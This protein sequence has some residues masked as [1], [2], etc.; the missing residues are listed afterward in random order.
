VNRRD[1]FKRLA[2]AGAA[3][4][5]LDGEAL[6]VALKPPI[7]QKAAQMGMTSHMIPELWARESMKILQDNMVMGNLVRKDFTDLTSREDRVYL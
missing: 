7:H 2:A 6:M 4:A 1:L 5:T 3:A